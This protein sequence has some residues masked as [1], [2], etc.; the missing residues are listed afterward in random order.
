MQVFELIIVIV[1]LSATTLGMI[2]RLGTRKEITYLP[3]LAAVLIG[4]H[5]LIFGY[6]WQMT[7]LIIY[8]PVLFFICLIQYTYRSKNNFLCGK[9]LFRITGRIVVSLLFVF[10]AIFPVLLP[11]KDLLPSD[12]PY[13]VGTTNYLIEDRAR[14]EIF[15]RD[16]DDHRRIQLSIWYPAE[17]IDN[18]VRETYWDKE[19]RTGE[20]FSR[21]A[22]IYPFW[23]THLSKVKTNSYRDAPCSSRK[24]SFPV[25]LYSHSYYGLDKENTMLM[26]MLASHGYVICSL[27][28]SYENVISLFPEGEEVNGDLEYISTLYDSHAEKEDQLYAEL[29]RTREQEQKIQLVKQILKVDDLSTQLLKERT[30]DAVLALN[31]LALI[32][33]KSGPLQQKLDLSRIGILGYSFGGATAMEACLTDP[34]F[35]A[36]INLDGLPYGEQF[37]QGNPVKQ[38]FMFVYSEILDDM[39]QISAELMFN[40]VDHSAY[41]LVIKGARHSNFSDFPYFFRIYERLGYWGPIPPRRML[42]LEKTFIRGF[43]D[44]YV[45]GDG[46]RLSEADLNDFPEISLKMK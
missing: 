42:E 2:P 8:T 3:V 43:F 5:L 15:T 18:F 30:K 40:Q 12:G 19:M 28:H 27:A 26:E 31:E 36:G 16:P 11:V 23:Y 35:S 22:E 34:R 6:R 9:R 14:E 44:Q 32:N 24:D 37:N 41:N 13:Q 45:K 10:S 4:V 20:A 39:E 46:H 38:P 7:L 17:G 1:L 29:N 21:S 25:I 33:Q